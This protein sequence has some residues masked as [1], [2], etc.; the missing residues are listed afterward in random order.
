MGNQM[1]L[2][3]DVLIVQIIRLQLVGGVCQKKQLNIEELHYP[4]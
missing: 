1:N 3:K 2:K 4:E